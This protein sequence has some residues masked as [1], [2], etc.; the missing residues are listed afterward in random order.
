MNDIMPKVARLAV[1]AL[2]GYAAGVARAAREYNSPP[3][4][5]AADVRTGDL[6]AAQS[7]L[8]VSADNLIVTAFQPAVHPPTGRRPTAEPARSESAAE[9]EGGVTIRAYEC[10]GRPAEAT[11]ELA[12]PLL[13]AAREEGASGQPLALTVKQQGFV[14]PVGPCAIETFRVQPAE[15]PA[16]TGEPLG[17]VAGP[18]DLVHCRYWDYNLGAGPIGGPPVGV[19]L[20]GD[21]AVGGHTRL[22]LTVVNEALDQDISGMVR[23]TA[24]ADWM[25]IPAQVPYRLGPGRHALYEIALTVPADASGF[26][27]AEMEHLDA[28]YQDAL[29]VGS[30]A[31][32]AVSLRREPDSFVVRLDNVATSP[33]SGEG[34]VIE[35][36]VALIT[37]MPTWGEVIRRPGASVAGRP[38]RCR[39]EPAVQPFFLAPGEQTELTFTAQPPGT[40]LGSG[41]AV[42]KVM[43]YGQVQY[44][45]E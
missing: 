28:R 12:F 6:P 44:V 26:L 31:P 18:G 16:P 30:P 17:P 22:T 15:V 33:S 38:D 4:A 27:R 45:R 14:A 39:I 11:F 40:V 42:A 21:I 43:Y 9:A 41:W 25:L 24:P 1:L 7:V 35:G 8:S 5:R 13:S 34:D 20:S 3:I 19:F 37:P 29:A 2:L 32:L 23:L 36:L 10:H